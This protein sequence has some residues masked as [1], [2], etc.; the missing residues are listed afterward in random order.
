MARLTSMQVLSSGTLL[1]SALA[2]TCV[3]DRSD[4][5]GNDL[6]APIVHDSAGVRIVD[7]GPAPAS[8][9][10][11]GTSPRFTL[12]WGVDEPTFT[13]IQSGRILPDGGAIVGDFTAGTIFW[14]GPAGSVLATWG[15][16]GEGPGEYQALDAILLR[17]DSILVS[18]GRLRRLTVL[19]FAG[20]VLAT[21]PLPGAFMHQASSFLT[22]GRL[23]LIPGDAYGAVSDTRP[24]WVFERQ[25]I[26]AASMD[27]GTIDTLAELPHLRRWYGTRGASPGPVSVRGRAEGFLGGFG[28]SR[29]DQPEVRWYDGAGRLLQI[30]RWDEEAMPLTQD[31]RHRMAANLEES[32]RSAGAEEGFIAAQLAELQ[33]GF[34]RHDGPLPFWDSFDVDRQGNAWLRE[35]AL[36][37]EPST[38]WRVITRDGVYVGWADLPNVR[39]IL[40]I[41]D[42]RI[43]A[44]RADSLDVPALVLLDLVKR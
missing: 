37:G 7:N 23:L 28:Y 43:L 39:S 20:D 32:W 5:S 4:G 44:V 10:Q 21:R 3:P 25:P 6:A 17:G 41:T 35:Y 38:R 24:E 11:V 27:G 34:A 13:W 14:I 29:A 2:T 30:A 33:E 22:D 40:D 16:K 26:I 15:R 1:F 42:S 19:S 8:S 36:P 12:G 18:D 31:W 9:W